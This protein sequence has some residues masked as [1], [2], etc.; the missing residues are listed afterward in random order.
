MT[1]TSAQRL[2]FRLLAEGLAVTD[3]ARQ[4]ILAATGDERLSSADY[5]STS[6]I[7]LSL[8]DDVWVNAPTHANNANFIGSAPYEL[9]WEGGKFVVRGS[10]LE[11]A[12]RYWPQ[13]KYHGEFGITREPLNR[14]VYTHADR[15]RLAPIQGCAMSCEFCNI[16]WEDEYGTKSIDGMVDA[17]QTA[18]NDPIQPA[19]HVLIS[20]G[21]PRVR[22]FGL[23]RETYRRVLTA[24]PGVGVDIMM[25]PVPGLLDLDELAKL[26][27][28]ELSI[29][30]EVWSDAIAAQLMRQKHRHGRG[31]YLQFIEDA[32]NTFGPRKVR[33]M[34][35]VGLE[36]IEDTLRGIE[37]IIQRGGV[38]VLSPFRPDPS[39]PLRNVP[40]PS[41][42]EL[43]EVFLRATDL[44]AARGQHLGPDCV[45]CSHNTLTLAG[46]DGMPAV[47]EHPMPHLV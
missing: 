24:L 33:S 2:K 31:H 21:T 38:P 44:A 4:M 1:L 20:G 16:P 45:P 43:E 17:L 18:L 47:Y 9:D 26:G 34:L 30:L 28:N 46:F 6:G 40:P 7:I 29:N 22:D 41:A 19:H 37:A 12:A 11:S 27:A 3:R 13:P 10:G 5:A 32:A 14:F 15:A 39:T 35:M 36:P 23:L 8:D 42:A 25:V